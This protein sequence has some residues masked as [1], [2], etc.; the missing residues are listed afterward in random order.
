[1]DVQKMSIEE[2]IALLSET[3]KAYLLGFVDRALQEASRKD[4]I[5]KNSSHKGTE[6][7]R[8]PR[9]R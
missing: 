3:D 4:A 5:I 6:T 1:M 8:T 7:Q 9:G 2:K